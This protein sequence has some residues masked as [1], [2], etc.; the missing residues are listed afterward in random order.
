MLQGRQTDPGFVPFDFGNDQLFTKVIHCNQVDLVFVAT[1]PIAADL[2]ILAAGGIQVV[3]EALQDLAGPSGVIA[4]D[5]LTD[6]AKVAGL[7]R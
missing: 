2:V 6:I 5:D 1:L 3:K 7:D 4:F